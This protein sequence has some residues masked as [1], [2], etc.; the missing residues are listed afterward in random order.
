MLAP[1]EVNFDDD[2]GFE[3]AATRLVTVPESVIV[4]ENAL[5]PIVD[6][7]LPR[8]DRGWGPSSTPAELQRTTFFQRDVLLAKRR[9]ATE[10]AEPT[11]T[12]IVP[13]DAKPN[14]RARVAMVASVCG[15]MG[16][17]IGTSAGF[18]LNQRD[19]VAA[20]SAPAAAPVAAAPVA[21]VPVAAV[22]GAA[23]PVAAAAVAVAPVAAPAVAAVAAAAPV[24]PAAVAPAGVAPPV[25]AATTPSPVLLLARARQAIR[26]VEPARAE[27]ALEIARTS[28][29]D[30][31]ALTQIEAQL[32]VLRGNGARAVPRLRQ[33]S[34]DSED[35]VLWVAL[36]RTLVQA[37]QDAEAGRAFQR[38]LRFDPNSVHSHV[39]LAR[40]HA[41]RAEVRV[42]QGHLDNAREALASLPEPDSLLEAR[43]RAAEGV[44]LFERG[45]V[46]A[47]SRAAEQASA[48]DDRSSDAWQ[49]MARIA[50]S[51]GEDMESHL[52]AAVAGRA[53]MPMAI[54]LLVP[55]VR[56]L[57][58][59]E[60]ASHYMERAPE[61]YDA[62]AMSRVSRRCDRRS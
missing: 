52:R 12:E 29:A 32:A 38:A 6:V 14:R 55:N 22:P 5:G 7:V 43:I 9:S 37:E 53:P 41:R 36:A 61:G 42:A 48:L 25:A 27:G 49:L 11:E 3:S 13:K 57:E 46:V 31:A 39:G 62:R 17:V 60:L 51:R 21:A 10:A 26:D 44:I 58:A 34:R 45:N 59:C 30:P 56:G 4:D 1:Q 35:P 2:G 50:E 54:G 18:A 19:W 8:A 16:I 47:A 24:A 20:A 28:G 40:I 15:V 23:V 33:L